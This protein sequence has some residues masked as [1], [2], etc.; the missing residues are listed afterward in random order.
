MNPTA[1]LYNSLMFTD[2]SFT[3]IAWFENLTIPDPYFV[4]PVISTALLWA[5]FEVFNLLHELIMCL[6]N[7]GVSLFVCYLNS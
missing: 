7:E 5:S 4:L 6:L 3:G 1:G 2:P